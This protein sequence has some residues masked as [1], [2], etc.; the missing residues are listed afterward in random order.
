MGRLH[1]SVAALAALATGAIAHAGLVDING[2]SSW[3]GWTSVGNSRTAGMWVKGST[4]RDYNIYSTLFTLEAAQ[5][6]GGNRLND[7]AGGS[8]T[9]YT[10]DTQASLFSGSWMAGDRIVGVGLQYVGTARLSTIWVHVDWTGDSIQAASSVGASDGAYRASAGDLSIYSLGGSGNERFRSKQYSVFTGPS[11]GSNNFSTPYGMSA[12]T[13]S[14]ARSFA[15]LA[16]GS[17]AAATSAQYFIN[18]DA[19]ARSNG[20]A[21]HGEGLLG[22]TTKLGFME[23]DSSWNLTQQVFS[24]PSAGA[25]ALLGAALLAPMRKPTRRR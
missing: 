23:A 21:G 3:N 25:M 2:G 15:V 13:A 8:G 9:A 16:N 24:I 6:V 14:P 22:P 4:T 18:L 1:R 7:G 11:D 5:T 19:I 10:G 20:G 12:T 17:T